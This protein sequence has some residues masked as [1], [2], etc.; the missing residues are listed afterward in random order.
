MAKQLFCVFLKEII[1]GDGHI[2]NSG[3]RVIWGKK[4]FL[5][6][7][8]GF[9]VTHGISANLVNTKERGYYLS[10]HKDKS[11]PYG[12]KQIYTKSCSIKKNKSIMWDVTVPNH[13]LFVECNGK[14]CVTHNCNNSMNT[15]I[16][17]IEIKYGGKKILLIHNSDDYEYKKGEFDLILCGHIHQAW[18]Q[19][20]LK[21]I[22]IV[23]VGVDVWD[24]RPISIDKILRKI[25]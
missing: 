24:Y 20:K 3:T 12:I 23:N 15:P 25:K 17:R 11:L 7:L 18:E 4:E 22:P 9:L 1:F 13:T 21:E 16:E 14:P 2:Q 8:L 10:V 6:D 19:K 5:Y